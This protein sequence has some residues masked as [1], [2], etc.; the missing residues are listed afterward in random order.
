LHL[1]GIPPVNGYTLKTP[2]KWN[3][4]RWVMNNPKRTPPGGRIDINPTVFF[5]DEIVNKV[6]KERLVMPIKT[7]NIRNI[8]Y[9]IYLWKKDNT[10][11]TDINYKVTFQFIIEFK[12][13]EAQEIAFK[14]GEWH[15]YIEFECVL[16]DQNEDYKSLKNYM[17]INDLPEYPK[18]RTHEKIMKLLFDFDAADKNNHVYTPYLDSDESL[19]TLCSLFAKYAYYRDYY[20]L[21]DL[22]LRK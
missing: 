18:Y 14:P 21:V 10:Q 6:L 13:T 20:K 11:N 3:I 12:K 16:P 15:H 4:I 9:D 2:N 5:G 19:N 7:D 17:P 1:G 8:N 22:R